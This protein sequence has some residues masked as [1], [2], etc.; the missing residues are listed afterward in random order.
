[1]DKLMREVP[2]EQL[3]RAVHILGNCSAAAMALADLHARRAAGQDACTYLTA[4]SYF[5]GPRL[6]SPTEGR[7]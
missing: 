7:S 2:D 1:M 3:E 5:V 6:P 4:G